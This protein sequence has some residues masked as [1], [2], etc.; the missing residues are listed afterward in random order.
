MPSTWL[1]MSKKSPSA[2]YPLTCVATCGS[3]GKEA[4]GGTARETL[5]EILARTEKEVIEKT[6]REVQFKKKEAAEL[7][8]ISTT[9]LWRK[10]VQHGLQK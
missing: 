2:T 10:M 3:R 1:K 8:G 9:T 7:L 6:L 4:G 5:D